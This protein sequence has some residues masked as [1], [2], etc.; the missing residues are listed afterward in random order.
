MWHAHKGWDVK[1]YYLPPP[2]GTKIQQLYE[3]LFNNFIAK[4]QIK[5]NELKKK[6]YLNKINISIWVQYVKIL[7]AELDVIWQNNILRFICEPWSLKMPEHATDNN[8]HECFTHYYAIEMIYLIAIGYPG[9]L[10]LLFIVICRKTR[11]GHS[12]ERSTLLSAR[13]L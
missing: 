7:I 9:I 4:N 2:F 10:L 11:V 1:S 12:W 3:Y 6:M 5:K 8:T 13:V